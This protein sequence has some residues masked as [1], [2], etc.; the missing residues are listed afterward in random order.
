ME[1]SMNAAASRPSALAQP[2]GSSAQLGFSGPSPPLQDFLKQMPPPKS[3]S[4]RGPLNAGT[5]LFRQ[6]ETQ[7]LA[8]EKEISPESGDLS[9]AILAQSQ[10][11]T[12]LVSQLASADPMTELASTGLGISSKGASGR[13]KLQQE[14]AMHRG[15][16]FTSVI[17]SMARRMSPA[18][19]SDASPQDLAIR[20]VT[21][22][23]YVERF[24]GFGKARDL[25]QL[26]WLVAMVLDHLQND[27]FNAAKDA[28]ALLA[29]CLE[30]AALDGGRLDLGLLLALAEDPPAGVFTNRTLAGYS[31]GRAFAPLAEQ[32]WVTT[33]LAF[34]KEM[35]LIASKRQDV[36]GK[37]EKDVPSSSSPRRQP[38]KQAKG[39][40]KKQETQEEEQ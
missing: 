2:L 27:N 29:V 4:S 19:S 17:Q 15:T 14:L 25:G 30:Q 13:A 37:Q 35:D 40:K 3:T 1:N 32:R 11:L 20:G 31:R 33:A 26:M 7:E 34:V 38:K 16:F 5:V 28:T 22:T 39:W 10:A 24:G 8:E 36:T 9:R 12:T 21:P 23:R 6:Q 18:Q